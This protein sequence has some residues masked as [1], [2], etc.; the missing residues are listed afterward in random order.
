MDWGLIC[1]SRAS[2]PE[3]VGPPRSSRASAELSGQRQLALRLDL[4]QPP[5]KQPHA[6]PQ[7]SGHLA[8]VEVLA[9]T[10]SLA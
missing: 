10:V 4:P 3:V 2:A 7:R 6:D 8:D 5:D 9:H 1:S